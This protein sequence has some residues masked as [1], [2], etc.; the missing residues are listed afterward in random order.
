MA[1]G[2][3]AITHSLTSF[4]SIRL[5]AIKRSHS[6]VFCLQLFEVR[7]MFDMFGFLL[8][9]LYINYCKFIDIFQGLRIHKDTSMSV[10]FMSKMASA[11]VGCLTLIQASGFFFFFLVDTVLNIYNIKSK[12]SSSINR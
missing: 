12:Y 7:Y 2:G 4:Q 6:R 3:L 10:N 8:Y 5:R 1:K 9:T 11:S